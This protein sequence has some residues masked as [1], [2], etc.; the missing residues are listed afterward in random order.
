MSDANVLSADNDATLAVQAA[1][2][3]IDV[4]TRKWDN[5]IEVLHNLGDGSE[6]MG[7]FGDRI[8]P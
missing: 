4:G 2:D 8:R 5:E 6:P 7:V 3:F 1:F